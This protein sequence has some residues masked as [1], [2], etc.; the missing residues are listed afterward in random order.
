MI[1]MTLRTVVWLDVGQ[2]PANESINLLEAFFVGRAFAEVVNERL[3]EFAAD[4]LA[5]L[6][7]AEAELRQAQKDFEDEVMARAHFEM[8]KAS[9]S[10]TEGMP[11]EDEGYSNLRSALAGP[12]DIDEAADNLRAEIAAARA[13]LRSLNRSKA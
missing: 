7:K 6:G 2:N 5:E 1:S 8:R 3:G 11:A 9:G 12:A 4:I 10:T 13:A